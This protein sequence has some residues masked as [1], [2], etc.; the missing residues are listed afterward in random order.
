MMSGGGGGCRLGLSGS[1]WRPGAGFCKHDNEH[2]GSINFGKSLD[3]PTY[4]QP[5]KRNCAS[6]SYFVASSGHCA[7]PVLALG[8]QLRPH[9]VVSLRAVTV[10]S[11][12]EL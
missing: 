10:A 8:S 5:L 12:S 6:W 1:E 7:L 2:L 4:C 9:L 3:F 11:R